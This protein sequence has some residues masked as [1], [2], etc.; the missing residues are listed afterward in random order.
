MFDDLTYDE[1][2]EIIYEMIENKIEIYELYY[3]LT[4]EQ[5]RRLIVRIAIKEAMRKRNQGV[6]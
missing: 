1:M 3:A 5:K 4:E 6:I 2:D